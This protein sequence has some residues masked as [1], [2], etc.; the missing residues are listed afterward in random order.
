MPVAP[1]ATSTRVVRLRIVRV[2]SGDALTHCPGAFDACRAQSDKSRSVP[3]ATDCGS[4]CNAK[5]A[6][7]AGTGVGVSADRGRGIPFDR[8]RSKRFQLFFLLGSH[9]FPNVSNLKLTFI[10]ELLREL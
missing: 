6:L 7:R 5:G 2:H 9:E 1:R 3:L 4:R 8:T 10:S